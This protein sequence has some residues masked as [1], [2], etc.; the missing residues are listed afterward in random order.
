MITRKTLFASLLT[1]AMVVGCGGKHFD[2]RS[3]KDIPEGPG[4]FSG[5]EGGFTFSTNKKAETSASACP[6]LSPEEYRE[7]Q[8]FR[9]WQ[10]AARNTVE[11]R[12]F[13][14]W[15]AWKANRVQSQR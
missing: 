1:V 10:D 8:A 4:L 5:D 14:D 13:Q 3:G 2:Y 12:E 7:F 11:Y 9:R 6:S 15:Q